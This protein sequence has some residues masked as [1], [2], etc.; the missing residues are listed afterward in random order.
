MLAC[1]QGQLAA[2]RVL[3]AF[4]ACYDVEDNQVNSSQSLQTYMSLTQP[5]PAICAKAMFS[6]LVA[7]NLINICT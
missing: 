2:M 6:K 5:G 3:L 1:D 4:G 7:T